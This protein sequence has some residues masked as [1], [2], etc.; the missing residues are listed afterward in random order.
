[1]DAKCSRAGPCG[2][3]KAQQG[4]AAHYHRVSTGHRTDQACVAVSPSFPLVPLGWWLTYA[5]SPRLVGW[6][7]RVWHGSVLLWVRI[8]PMSIHSLVLGSCSIQV[9]DAFCQSCKSSASVGFGSPL[10]AS[11]P[12]KRFQTCRRVLSLA[13]KRRIHRASPRFLIVDR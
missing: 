8:W 13:S 12:E 9:A 1:M 3:S 5:T 4:N 7:P 6:R 2:Q 10:E 11:H